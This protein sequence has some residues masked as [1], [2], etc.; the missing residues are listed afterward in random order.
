MLQV[1]HLSD[2]HFGDGQLS[3]GLLQREGGLFNKRLL[4]FA[5]RK[6]NRKRRFAEERKLALIEYC[7]DLDFDYL[8]LS[9][10]LTH[11]STSAEFL[12]ARAA[13]EPLLSKVPG[14]VL[15]TA[16]NHDRYTRSATQEK[17][18]ELH[19]GDCFPF[20][21][22]EHQGPH[23]LIDPQGWMFLELPM[24]RPTGLHSKGKLAWNLQA[25]R[26]LLAAYPNHQKLLYGHYPL[27]YPGGQSEAF[28]HS[29][30]GRK[31][32]LQLL[33][34]PGVR[35][36]LHGHI[37]HSW[38]FQPFAETDFWSVNAGGSVKEGGYLISLSAEGLPWISPSKL[39]LP[40]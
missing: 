30:A 13:L 29:L 26:D 18:L 31:E 6:F 14:R 17:L 9:G 8:I 19:F 11:L 38:A 3:L 22:T 2:L 20:I 5:N 37:H 32:V 21:D 36:Y 4:G 10:D 28:S 35:G 15:L 25:Y 1:L 24:S 34:Q 16:G 7:M 39:E 27:V 23:F 33:K 40:A 12:E